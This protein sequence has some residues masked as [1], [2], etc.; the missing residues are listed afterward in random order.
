[1][2]SRSDNSDGRLRT[3]V[4]P[5]ATAVDEKPA[6]AV[7]APVPAAAEQH[8]PERVEKIEKPKSKGFTW[9]VLING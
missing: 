3:L 5:K 4:H 8:A 2:F 7:E 6:P 1:M 9:G